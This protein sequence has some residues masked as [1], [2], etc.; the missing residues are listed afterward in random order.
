MQ[1]E[2]AVAHVRQAPEVSLEGLTKT[3][4]N[5]RLTSVMSQNWHLQNANQKLCRMMQLTQLV[6]LLRYE[7][8]YY[9][10]YVDQ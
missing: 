5:L 2:A 4:K 9:S 1:Q 8:V 6:R 10:K 7:F 3:R